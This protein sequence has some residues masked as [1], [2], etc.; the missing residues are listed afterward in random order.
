MIAPER[1]QQRQRA[2]RAAAPAALP[3]A[4][5][6]ELTLGRVPAWPAARAREL[7]AAPDWRARLEALLRED[8][9]FRAAILIASAGLRP[10]VA[11]V[12]AGESLDERAATRLLAYAVRMSTRTTPFGTFAS[13]G[14]AAF[15]AE[16]ELLIDDARGRVAQA[17]VDHEW[18]VG[19]V[20]TLAERA[21]A[22]GEDVLVATATALRREG[23]R[24]AL[25]DERKV[26]VD[27]D[28]TQYRSVTVAATPPVAFALELARGG[29][30]SDEL[31]RALAETFSVDAERA[32]SLL[33]K[34]S[35]RGS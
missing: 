31:A 15:D 6:D 32:R 29:R 13:V 10:V 1:A 3:F 27:A 23:P 2:A 24:F 19:A 17:N 33:R 8:E 34:L 21:I 22:D 4:V 7:L 16:H 14:H 12:L 20:D 9:S 28:A 18:L 5:I 30:S 35:R 26:V 25:L 11:R